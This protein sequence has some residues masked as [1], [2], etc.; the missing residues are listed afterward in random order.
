[1]G[2]LD[3]MNLP[4]KCPFCGAGILVMAGGFECRN[5]RWA[6]FDC[7]TSI[8]AG[9]A[10][11][12][13]Q[14]RTCED[15]ERTR[16]AARVAELEAENKALRDRFSDADTERNAAQAALK[17]AFARVAELEAR[18][19]QAREDEAW[20]N[21]DGLVELEPVTSG[22]VASTL[23]GLHSINATAPTIR[24]ALRAL[25]DVLEAKP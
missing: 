1:M 7:R 19:K 18:E 21:G 9:Q 13:T 24:G 15:A 22:W 2:A 16:L 3:A 10:E 12:R 5:G 25:R 4:D 20:A 8:H 14:S 17:A 11:R 6:T 23:D